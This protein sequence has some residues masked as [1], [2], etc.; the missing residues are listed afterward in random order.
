M[1]LSQG[2]FFI[3]FYYKDV[4]EVAGPGWFICTIIIR[5]VWDYMGTS[6]FLLVALHCKIVL[7]PKNDS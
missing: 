5:F 1:N 7:F 3:R 4:Y 6:T 2:T